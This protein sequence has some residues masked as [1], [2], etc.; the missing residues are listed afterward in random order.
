MHEHHRD[1]KVG[2][3]E[4]R[5]RPYR[6]RFGAVVI[7]GSATLDRLEGDDPE[8]LWQEA[9]DAA[10]RRNP[11]FVGYDGAV[12][13]FLQWF[14][15]G[16]RSGGFDEHERGYKDKARE[17]LRATLP[18][19]QAGAGGREAGEA[20]LAVFRAT[21]LLSPYEKT[22]VQNV[23]RSAQAQPFLAAAAGFAA[24][25]RKAGLVEMAKALR[26]HNAAKWAVVTYLPF[27]W[28]PESEMF[29]KPQVTQSFAERVGHRFADVYRADLDLEV[30]DALLDLVQEARIKLDRLDLRDNIDL[31]SVIWV[32]GD[33]TDPSDGP[34]PE[35]PDA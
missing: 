31:Q 20:A 4:V 3:F 9:L 6:G 26:P 23:L 34:P 24:G 14:P 11:H 5:L 16:I 28:R 15:K 30:Y 8:V 7:D 2:K 17:K 18:L 22:W 35:V 21:N 19:A 12:S 29:L 1:K 13:R 10:A 33:Y 27:L 25:D 32:V